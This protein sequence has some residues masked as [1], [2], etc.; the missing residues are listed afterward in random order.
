MRKH[1]IGLLTALCVVFLFVSCGG[2]EGTAIRVPDLQ[3][4]AT[5]N[6]L[7]RVLITGV[8]P[9]H[10]TDSGNPINLGNET[11]GVGLTI[12]KVPGVFFSVRFRGSNE[13][14]SI[15]DQGADL[16]FTID[17]STTTGG[18]WPI[19]IT[20]QSLSSNRS[21]DGRNTSQSTLWIAL[22]NDAPDP[23]IY[24][25]PAYG[26]S[27][28]PPAATLRWMP[29]SDAQNDPITYYVY[30][31][32]TE[33]PPLLSVQTH[34]SYVWT[35]LEDELTYYWRVDASD[36]RSVG[37]RDVTSGPL[38]AF[39]VV[40][41]QYHHPS[42]TLL[43]P[44]DEATDQATTVQFSW[45]ASP[46][47]PVNHGAR[48]DAS[49]LA[50]AFYLAKGES[51]FGA[52]QMLPADA[53]SVT[54][55]FLDYESN[56]RWRVVVFQSNGQE[57][58]SPIWTFGTQAALVESVTVSAQSQPSGGG[59]IQIDDRGW[60]TTDSKIYDTGTMATLAAQAKSGWAFQTWRENDIFVST[61]NPYQFSA[62]TNRNLVAWFVQDEE[63]NDPPP[64]IALLAPP[65]GSTNLPMDITFQWTASPGE[66]NSVENRA[67]LSI[68]GFAFYLAHASA[69]FGAPV[70]LPNTTTSLPFTFFD[71][72]TDFKWKV[73]AFQS[74]GQETESPIWT[75][76][77]QAAPVESVTVSAQRQPSGGGW[78]Q[79]DN[80]GWK[81]TDSKT[82]NA[83]TTVT[84]AAQPQ[85]DWSF[86]EWR[87]GGVFVGVDNP[88]VFSANTN[89]SLVAW[90]VED[91]DDDDDDP[92]DHTSPYKG[93]RLV[94]NNQN[95]SGQTYQHTGSLNTASSERHSLPRDL[96]LEAYKIDAVLPTPEGLDHNDL[97]SP[98][99]PV[100]RYS[101]GEQ[102][103]FWTYNFKTSSFEK[104][105]AQ[106]R[107]IG[108]HAL[109]WVSDEEIDGYNYNL[110]ITNDQAN[111]VAAEFDA[112]IYPMVTTHFY[113]PSDVNGDGKIAILLFDIQDNFDSTGSYVGGYFYSGDLYTHGSSNHME[114]F[115]IDTYPTMH[116]YRSNPI[117]VTRSYSTIAHEFQHMVN[118]NR[119]VLI[120][121][122]YPM[123]LWINEA[124]S[125]A[126]EH[127]IYGV[128]TPRIQ[129]YNS[130]GHI[131]DGHSLLYWDSWNPLP[132]YALSYLFMQYF[133]IQMGQ[134][135]GIYRQLIE[136]SRNDA[137]ALQNLLNVHYGGMAL[138]D[139]LVQWRIAM[140]LK[141][142]SGP[143]GFGRESAFNT[144]QTLLY[145][146]TG[147]HLRGGG[148][149][150]KSKT[151]PFPH[152]GDSGSDIQFIG[153]NVP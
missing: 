148:T 75:F 139:F 89:R 133:R 132:N 128:L 80:R 64:T 35:G 21:P 41:Q 50:I 38:W 17:L 70:M 120:E 24:L 83:G 141:E 129:F 102:R 20:A 106:L 57:A 84:L 65:N 52:P 88:Y 19:Q 142:S 144:V 81:T 97:V 48:A 134:G 103:E 46:G 67:E 34:E 114:I 27:I 53:S 99:D 44:E 2:A 113:T 115:Y 78:I 43:S 118:F 137:Q 26:A 140:L 49:L 101:L 8:T 68:T 91:E 117:Y 146:G 40:E 28:P 30:G 13:K 105:N 152:P 109:V 104:I 130:S 82:Y 73:V 55:G 123:E 37:L 125:L 10:H 112:T 12:K 135:N 69:P 90:F 77:T 32:P 45:T 31:G 72:S 7:V 60:K 36:G 18:I 98:A 150:I 131:R 110:L 95:L 4:D 126:A 100:P 108:T 153:V 15:Q 122:G 79:I 29:G 149:L 127:L 147:R 3:R 63:E 92:F 33:N 107:A 62:K 39:T 1:M 51:Y 136:N 111:Q 42:I 61:D 23:L 151:Q 87:E 138:A 25:S 86:Q 54:V 143:Y 93:N 11:Q 16:L 74:D 5:L 96:P 14:I 9:S 59:W 121:K 116:R 85:S 56:Y 71:Y 119:N 58:E 145:L 66:S 6:A 94:V 124:L 47:D 76:R 22:H